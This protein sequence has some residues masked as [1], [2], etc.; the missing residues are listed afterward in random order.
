M[1]NPTA[2]D[3]L[4]HVI[5]VSG[6][7]ELLRERAVAT[8]RAAVLMADPEAECSE[9]TGD[10]LTMAELDNMSA[11]SLFS[12][13]RFVV[14]REL[15]DTPEPSFDVL[16][17]HAAAPPEDV[18]LVL[19]HSG[20]A[21]GSGLLTKLRKVPTVTEVKS[22][23]PKGKDIVRFVAGEVKARG[24]RIAEQAA[25]LLVKAVGNDLRALAGAADQLASDFPDKE[26]TP[27]VVRRYFGGRAEVKGFE[28]ADHA[29]YGRTGKALEELRWA[30]EAGVGAPA[31]TGSFAATV[32]GLA[33]VKAGDQSGVPPW[34]MR[35]LREQARG[36]DERGLAQAIT[37][38]ATADADVKGQA[39]DAAYALERMVLT[40]CGARSRPA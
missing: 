19:V 39:S 12:N 6:P 37:A 18:G 14:V 13:V 21:K 17:A 31:I 22:E 26:L 7:E 32:R 36:W 28:I 5:L 23:S 29:L 40:I 8:A 16:L 30:L 15:E 25:E 3:V 24:G 20:G 11:P 34:K 27:D 10:Q 35:I 38:V 33:R 9:T 1:A 4:G 2:S